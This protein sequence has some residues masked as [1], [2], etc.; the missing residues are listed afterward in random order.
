MIEV[1]IGWGKI[2]YINKLNAWQRA[3]CSFGRAVLSSL[4]SYACGL[5]LLIGPIYGSALRQ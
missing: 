3:E 5:P 2:F 4:T 1:A